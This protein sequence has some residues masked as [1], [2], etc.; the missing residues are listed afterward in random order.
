[1]LV[2]WDGRRIEFT[3][4]VWTVLCNLVPDVLEMIDDVINSNQII[5]IPDIVDPFVE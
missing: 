3:P 2:D 4:D 5:T 1:M